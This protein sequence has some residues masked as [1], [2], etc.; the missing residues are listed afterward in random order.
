MALLQYPPLFQLPF[1][2]CDADDSDVSVQDEP[3]MQIAS[4]VPA[5][6]PQGKQDK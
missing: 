1:P 3:I 4:E 6:K 5:K 2:G